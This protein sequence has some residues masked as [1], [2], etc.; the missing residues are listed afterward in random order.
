MRISSL[1]ILTFL[2]I[3]GACN[4]DPR[5]KLPQTGSFGN[6][7]TTSSELG[8]IPISAL[9]TLIA[10][11]QEIVLEGKVQKVCQGEGCWLSLERD[12][13]APVL[14]EIKDKAFQLPSKIEGKTARVN[15]ILTTDSSDK[16]SR[17]I[18]A[19]GIIIE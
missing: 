9:D 18:L 6:S 16:Y 17:K 19:D 10:A 5:E 7:K 13:K 4:R 8:S 11:N 14:I 2:F 1:A 3:V 12:G 15:G